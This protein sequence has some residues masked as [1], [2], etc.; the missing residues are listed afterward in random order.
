M[1]EPGGSGGSQNGRF[2]QI[3][4]YPKRVGAS[5]VLFGT[6]SELV[7]RITNK[8]GLFDEPAL[9]GREDYQRIVLGEPRRKTKKVPMI[10]LAD[11]VLY[12]MAKGGYDPA[13]PPYQMLMQHDKLI[14]CFFAEDAAPHRGIK[15]SCFDHKTQKRP[16]NPGLFKSGLLA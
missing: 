10:Q 13:Y 16:G 2:Q 11:L 7:G 3:G 1:N 5:L 15:Y 8:F 4:D 14:D 9:H 12:P 6:L